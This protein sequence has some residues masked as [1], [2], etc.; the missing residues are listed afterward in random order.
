MSRHEAIDHLEDLDEA[1]CLRLLETGSLGRVGAVVR[2]CP[3]I[4]P[5]NY[6]AFER[7]IVFLTRLGGELDGATADVTVAFE[8]DGADNVYHEGWSVLAIGRCAHVTGPLER[9]GVQASRLS[10]WAGSGRDLLV[11][12]S[13]DEISGR[14]IRHHAP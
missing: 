13:I 6:V 5:V 4:F 9:D 7:T 10:S 11:R 12:I 8:I 2:D 3:I 1:E 14:R